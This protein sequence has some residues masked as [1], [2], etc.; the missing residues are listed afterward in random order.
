MRRMCLVRDSLL[1]GKNVD[2]RKPWGEQRWRAQNAAVALEP[3][4][5][6]AGLDDDLRIPADLD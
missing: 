4:R 6:I 3:G 5:S 2:H 1:T